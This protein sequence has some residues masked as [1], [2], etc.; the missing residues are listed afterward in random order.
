M[1]GHVDAMKGSA[2]KVLRDK[3]FNPANYD[4]SVRPVIDHTKPIN[5]SFGLRLSKLIELV[6][7]VTLVTH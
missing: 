2:E 4:R 6:K 5:V 3:L 7:H 1:A